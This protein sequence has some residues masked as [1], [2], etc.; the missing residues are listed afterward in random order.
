MPKE[1]RTLL[2]MHTFNGEFENGGVHQFFL[3]SSGAL[4]PEVYDA[5]IEMGLE[6]QAAIFKRGLDMF[7]GNYPRDTTRRRDRFF[8]HSDWTEWDKKLSGL[9]D[10]FYAL[11]GGPTV[12]QVGGSAAIEGG[13]GIWPAMAVYARNKKLLP[14]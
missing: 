13:P 10:E 7:G 1:Q 12:L 11:D 8:D 2:A 6:R 9:T 3:N 5:F 14:C 4:A